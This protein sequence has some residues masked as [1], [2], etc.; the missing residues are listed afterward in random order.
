MKNF[1]LPCLVPFIVLPAEVGIE[2]VRSV[3]DDSD[4]W[5]NWRG[6]GGTGVASTGSP[7]VEWSEERNIRWKDDLPG[8]GSSSPI[9]WEDRVYVM[10]AIETDRRGEGLPAR[11]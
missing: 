5:S 6:P 10:T 9:V 1:I 7:P 3:A 4:W 8:L 11:Q 2:P